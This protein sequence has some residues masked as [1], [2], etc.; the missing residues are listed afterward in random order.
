[1]ALRVSTATSHSGG[2]DSTSPLSPALFPRPPSRSEVDSLLIGTGCEGPGAEGSGAGAE[3][4]GCEAFAG[5]VVRPTDAGVGG[6]AAGEGFA[7]LPLPGAL[8]LGRLEGQGIKVSN[9]GV[10]EV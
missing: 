5:M 4:S 9:S 8:I 6:A 10:N 2:K 1:M 7:F 3:G